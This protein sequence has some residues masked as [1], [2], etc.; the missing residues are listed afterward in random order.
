LPAPVACSNQ[1]RRSAFG[2]LAE[3]QIL[4]VVVLPV[5]RLLVLRLVVVE[6]EL[7]I[8]LAGDRG[9]G[10]LWGLGK[11]AAG[12]ISVAATVAVALGLGQKRGERA[13]QRVDL[14]G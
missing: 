13:R 10:Q 2:P 3:L 6:V 7:G 5:L 12:L 9:R 1:K 11:L 14:V 8:L 4:V